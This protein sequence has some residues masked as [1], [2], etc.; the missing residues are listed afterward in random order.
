MCL[1]HSSSGIFILC[2]RASR[3]QQLLGT[4]KTLQIV[5]LIKNLTC[6][7]TIDSK[8]GR[9]NRQP[10]PHTPPSRPPPPLTPSDIHRLALFLS[11][12]LWCPNCTQK[13]CIPHINPRMGA[14]CGGTAV[15]KPH[16]KWVF[17]FSATLP[18]LSLNQG[19]IVSERRPAPELAK[20][21]SHGVGRRREGG[22]GGTGGYRSYCMLLSPGSPPGVGGFIGLH[23]LL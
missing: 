13:L 22:T 1:G 21:L 17:S 8:R 5:S 23:A 7:N 12:S 10:E 15:C 20:S 3:K 6:R 18:A 9:E 14:V 2:G 19:G 11:V 4:D 16:C